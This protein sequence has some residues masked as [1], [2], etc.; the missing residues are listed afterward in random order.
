ME[1]YYSINIFI[2]GILL[3]S[4]LNVVIYRLPQHESIIWGRS[5]CMHCDHIIKPIE[6]IP[7]V[8]F[9]FLG[10]KCKGC[11]TPISLRYPLIELLTGILFLV[12]YKTF[13]FS[14]AFA[15]AL[16]LTLILIIIA[17]IDIDTMEIYDRFQIMILIL[18]L[19]NLFVS[20]LS[21]ID[22]I[23]G[24]FIISIPFYIIAWLTD[25]M[26]GGDIKLIAIA[27]LLLGYQATLVA[28]FV[29]I[30]LGA[31]MALYLLIVKKSSG[32]AQLAFGPFLCIGIYVAYHFSTIII[33]T[34]LQ[35]W[36]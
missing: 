7:V 35:I 4:F 10:G 29:S 16:P 18:A 24:F 14:Y 12:S 6:L 11:K 21:I 1:L 17:F 13:G 30:I 2:L 5:H 33:Q 19:L 25:G 23:T 8:S 28:F 32:K 3:G 9:V 31:L 27:G 26:G 15:I 22:H 36:L 20:P 34:Y